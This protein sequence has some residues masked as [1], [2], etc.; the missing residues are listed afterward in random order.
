TGELEITFLLSFCRAG[1][2][3]A[4]LQDDS[5]MPISLR[6]FIQ[7]LQDIFDPAPFEPESINQSKSQPLEDAISCELVKRLNSFRAENCAW[8]AS[9]E[10]SDL[11]AIRA[12]QFAPVTSHAVFETGI[13]HEGVLY[14]T[15][16]RDPNNSIIHVVSRS[17]GATLFG[18]IVSIFRHK[19]YPTENRP[20]VLDTWLMVKYFAP[21]PTNKP[22]PFSKI[23]LPDM[24]VHLHLEI[25]ST[26]RL[27]HISEVIA[28]CAWIVYE[29]QEI[30]FLLNMKTIAMVSVDR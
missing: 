19:R 21:V 18:Q 5:K 8:L 20:P 7:Q 15:L 23:D 25:A 14:T 4:L 1:N 24:Q 17:N 9:N 13:H 10:W 16:N 6:P 12:A 2:I 3:A 22:N 29:P 28:Q 30:H 27:T 26:P 11:P